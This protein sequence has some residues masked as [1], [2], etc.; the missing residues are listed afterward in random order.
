MKRATLVI[1][2]AIAAG[3]AGWPAR[4]AN[5][6]GAGAP[7][8]LTLLS[9]KEGQLVRESVKVSIPR[10]AVPD[11]GFVVIT[12]DGQFQ[13]ALSPPPT[14]ETAAAEDSAAPATPAQPETLTWI[15]DTKRLDP[16]TAKPLAARR[17]ADGEHELMV[18]VLGSGGN[19]V[20]R[21]RAVVRVENQIAA[22]PDF[23]VRLA[24]RG[25]V[26]DMWAMEHEVSIQGRM[27]QYYRYEGFPFARFS[28]K[29][30]SR[31]LVSLEDLQPGTSSAFVGERR[32]SPILLETH[33]FK[34]RIRIPPSWGYYSLG[35]RGEADLSS[36]LE[37][38][39]RYPIANPI[40]LPGRV[41]R[42][43]ETFNTTVRVNL[44]AYVPGLLEIEDVP[45]RLEGLEWEGGQR[46]VRIRV[47]YQR[48][49]ETSRLNILSLRIPNAEFSIDRG[50][51]TIWFAYEAGR[52]VR[53]EH[54]I[55]GR[56][57]VD[58]RLL[59]AMQ[60]VA[61]GVGGGAYEGIP[62][63]EAGIGGPMPPGIGGPGMPPG[64]A[65]GVPGGNGPAAF[66]G[67]PGAGPYG[68]GLGGP[69]GPYGPGGGG[70]YG[71]G[72]GPYG[73]GGGAP[74]G[75]GGRGFPG[76]GRG[77]FGGRFGPPG[78]FDPYGGAAGDETLTAGAGY[79]PAPGGYG[80]PG[81]PP[82]AG[83]PG[84]PGMPG[85][86][87]PGMPGSFATPQFRPIEDYFV[88][89]KVDTRTLLE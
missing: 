67:P 57:K 33:L 4:S 7:G 1:L 26:G 56:L 59:P 60:T 71:A 48:S 83:M 78:G 72:A 36:R 13:V 39:K 17:I 80:P 21:A 16:D 44:G 73:Q 9:P 51:S 74:R 8:A 23:P 66:G 46:T 55:A 34:Q 69:Y 88:T 38:E 45:A 85:G 2:L 82:G 5:T 27:L 30:R 41:V 61:P 86:F 76:R 29:E 42:L 20:G 31:H 19:E 22:P 50:Q 87:G 70:P 81:M 3:M 65:P 68:A 10:S 62:G 18:R 12:V 63:G 89:I 43:N 79:G 47:D 28:H 37:R 53:V 84:A 11:G 54:D 77:G 14:D 6:Q 35:M 25:N 64:G 32:D 15:W 24:Y 40:D 52:V 75:A 58:M 49:N